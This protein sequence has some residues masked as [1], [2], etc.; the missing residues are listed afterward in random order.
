MAERTGT[1][2]LGAGLTGLAAALRLKTRRG[3]RAL[4]VER[5]ARPGG[6]LKTNRRDG[7]TID[8]LP[9]LF[10]TRDPVADALFR[11]MAGPVREHRHRLGVMWKGGFV[12]YPFQNHVHQLDP[13]DR[14]RVLLDLLQRSDSRAIAPRNL[15]QFALGVLGRGITDLFF[16]PYNQKLLQAPLAALDHRWVAAKIRMPRPEELADSILGTAPAPADVAPH[17]EFYYPERGGIESLVEGLVAAVGPEAIRRGEEVLG[18]DTKRRRVVTSR[19]TI[20]YERLLSTLPLDRTLALSGLPAGRAAAGRLRATR[21]VTIH[22]VVKDVRLPD[23]HWIYVPDPD[24]SFYRLT[25]VDLYNPDAA[26]GARVLVAECAQPPESACNPDATM[27]T[28]MDQLERLGVLSRDAIL[29]RW[30]FA[31][32]PAYPVPHLGRHRDVPALLGRLR[33]SGILSAGRFGEWVQ[34]N[35]DHCIASAFAAVDH[36]WTA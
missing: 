17:A 22:L 21:V 27:A 13:A 24:L 3:E 26:P 15:E 14:R 35:M 7:V 11:G 2:I 28:A 6:L 18:I 8:V 34:H 20:E 33:S 16:R 32:H 1:L 29:A 23:Y 5:D 9:H 30:A 36:G 31:T 25:R 4:L 12:D 10:F 19:G